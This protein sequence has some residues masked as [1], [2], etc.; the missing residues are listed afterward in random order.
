MAAKDQF[1]S[2]QKRFH[3]ISL[4]QGFSDEE[5]ARDWTISE[6]DIGEIN[7]HRTAITNRLQPTPD[8]AMV[9]VVDSTTFSLPSGE[10]CMGRLKQKGN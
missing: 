10:V 5:M 4:P 7:K 3:P 2:K 9:I 1:L 8:T 6:N